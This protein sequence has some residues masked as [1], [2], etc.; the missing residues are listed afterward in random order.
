MVHE[1]IYNLPQLFY[2]YTR[3]SRDLLSVNGIWEGE[4]EF[5]ENS[6]AH[7]SFLSQQTISSEK[8]K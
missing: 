5:Q 3:Q 1:D 8:E 2:K 4:I 6:A 7:A